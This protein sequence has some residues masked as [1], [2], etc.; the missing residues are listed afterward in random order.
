MEAGLNLASI[1][2]NI[3]PFPDY[4]VSPLFSQL[5]SINSSRQLA[6]HYAAVQASLTPLQCDNFARGLR[7]TFG[8]Q[9]QVTLGGVGVVA[10]SLAV[11]FDTLAKQ[12]KGLWV[13]ESGPIP[14]LFH[15]DHGRKDQ[16]VVLLISSYLR[17]VPYI[18]N[19]PTRMKQ[20]SESCYRALH[21]LRL[22][23]G[24][25]RKLTD[26]EV[27]NRAKA[28]WFT[29]HLR[30]HLIRISNLTEVQSIEK[31]VFVAKF[32]YS[33]GGARGRRHG[34]ESRFDFSLNCDAEVASKEFLEE[35]E[36]SSTTKKEYEECTSQMHVQNPVRYIASVAL[37][38]FI[39]QPKFLG[40][41]FNE[42]LIAQ[43]DDFDLRA[44]SRGN[45]GL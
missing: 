29:D 26:V 4:N 39:N 41:P 2:R 6:D 42:D 33:E 28:W 32:N 34:P 31:S 7:T 10:L 23:R 14:G 11:L 16:P 43:R 20:E 38:H 8:K 1:A 22:D 3:C 17:L 45:W 37:W 21:D 35:V 13:P 5:L 9:G 44:N 27:A 25:G 15:K 24:Q 30:F 36:Q 18:A 40:E 19:N 12:E